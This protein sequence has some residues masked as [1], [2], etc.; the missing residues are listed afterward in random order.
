MTV[1][2]DTTREASRG[3][4]RAP[5]EPGD[6][7]AAPSTVPIVAKWLGGLGALPFMFLAAVGVAAEPALAEVSRLALAAYGAVILSF[8]GGIHWGLAIAG[9]GPDTSVCR[10]ARRLAYSV[11]PALVGWGALF[12][13][14]PL[15]LLILA[16]AFAAM[17]LFDA[18]ASRVGEAPYWYRRL[19]LPLTV[20]VVASLIAG[21]AG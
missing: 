10:T 18:R 9:L 17:L 7:I 11:V 21:A 3:E 20:V 14:W 8:L 15:G 12:V 16:A 6:A 5:R 19:R 2:D 1:L 13:V 4:A